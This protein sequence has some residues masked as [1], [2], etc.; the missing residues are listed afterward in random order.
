MHT[1]DHDNTQEVIRKPKVLDDFSRTDAD[2][3][4]ANLI[5]EPVN[6]EYAE[7]FY[8]DFY[9][10]RLNRIQTITVLLA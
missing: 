8:P 1:V 2:G 5:L 7:K 3:I 4:V 10:S 9:F 6:T